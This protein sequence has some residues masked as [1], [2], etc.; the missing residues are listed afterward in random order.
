MPSAS[1]NAITVS[2]IRR[3]FCFCWA[4]RMENRMSRQSPQRRLRSPSRCRSLTEP[5]GV[6]MPTSCV[7]ATSTGRSSPISYMKSCSTR[8]STTTA[9][10]WGQDGSGEAKHAHIRSTNSEGRVFRMNIESSASEHCFHKNGTD[11]SLYVFEAPSIS[12]PTSP[13]THTAGRSTATSPA[14]GH[15]SSRCWNGCGRIQSWTRC[16]SAST[17]M[18]RA[19]TPA[20]A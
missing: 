9:F 8:T 19:M 10:S 2:L 6:C 3:R 17:T 14:A 7:S 15:P 16:T 1:R 18:T 4:E 5:C 20:T 12:C 11:K 13:S